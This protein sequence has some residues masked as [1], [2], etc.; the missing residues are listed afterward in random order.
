MHQNIN[1]KLQ[2]EVHNGQT[3][4]N[5]YST[6]KSHFHTSKHCFAQLPKVPGTFSLET[7]HVLWAFVV[8]KNIL[9]EY[10]KTVE[11][12]TLVREK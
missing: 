4:N 2:T 8:V 9:Q 3:D 5:N 1:R 10:F 7:A 6:V 12:F 11:I